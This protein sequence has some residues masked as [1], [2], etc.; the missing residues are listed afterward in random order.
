M[1]VAKGWGFTLGGPAWLRTP[2]G[3]W[4][5]PGAESGEGQAESPSAE[6]VMGRGLLGLAP[7]FLVP[8]S[9]MM[10]WKREMGDSALER[11]GEVG[12]QQSK[13]S[14][15]GR[16][17]GNRGAPQ[18]GHRKVQ[19]ACFPGCLKCSP[20]CKVCEITHWSLKECLIYSK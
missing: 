19:Q 17:R 18:L 13:Q 11:V 2:P 15:S 5:R 8:E 14:C 16:K 7:W 12:A 9:G 6:N 10:T 4:P 1:Q 3:S 20:S